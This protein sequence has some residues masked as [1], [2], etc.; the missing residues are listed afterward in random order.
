MPSLSHAN[1][2]HQGQVWWQ[3]EDTLTLPTFL[4]GCPVHFVWIWALFQGHFLCPISTRQDASVLAK[5]LF[6]D[7]GAAT[8][9]GGGREAGSL[10]P[11][12]SDDV[13]KVKRGTLPF[14]S[15]VSVSPHVSSSSTSRGGHPDRGRVRIS[16][17]P[18]ASTGCQ[19]SQS[20]TGIWVSPGDTG[21]DWKVQT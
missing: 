7:W 12:S 19:S 4:K 14:Q 5:F 21:V 8:M 10:P 11:S 3:W 17:S 9:W 2:T 20:S 13:G 16:P 15:N 6:Q 18:Q 1:V